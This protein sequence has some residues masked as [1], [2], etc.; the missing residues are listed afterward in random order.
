MSMSQDPKIMAVIGQNPKAQ[1]MMAA[2]MAH[3][4]EHAAYAYRMQIEQQM[5]MPLPPE[6]SDDENGPKIP[7]EMQNMLSGAMAQAAQQLLQQH[8]AEQAQQQAQQ[9]Q[10]DPIVQ[11]QQQELQIRQ[12]EVQIKQQEAEMKMQISQQEMQL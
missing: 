1:E 9:A 10:Q 11:M 6:G 2:G 8:K 3:I 7:V 12:Q 4:A 5:G